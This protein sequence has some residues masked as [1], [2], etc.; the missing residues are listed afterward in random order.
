MTIKMN[1]AQK[2][3]SNN[4]EQAKKILEI[5]K[6]ENPTLQ[7]PDIREISIKEISKTLM[8]SKQTSTE[9]YSLLV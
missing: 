9:Y 5:I 2:I 6:T 4:M 1:Y 3:R 7:E 8:L